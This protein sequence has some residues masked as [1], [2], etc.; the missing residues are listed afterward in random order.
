MEINAAA[1]SSY[2]NFF[3]RAEG[4]LSG[5]RIATRFF[6]FY[7]D[8]GF[9]F[10]CLYLFTDGGNCLGDGLDMQ[11]SHMATPQ[12]Q[13]Q[14]H[15]VASS[16][17]ASQKKIAGRSAIVCVQSPGNKVGCNNNNNLRL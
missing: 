17:T 13:S 12:P 11:K 14:S 4:P 16:L 8:G 2:K 9:I 6:F 10:F 15:I 3:V 7:W 1:A 5:F